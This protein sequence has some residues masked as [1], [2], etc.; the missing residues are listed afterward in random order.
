MIVGFFQILVALNMSELTSK[1]QSE[2]LAASSDQINSPERRPSFRKL[3]SHSNII[4]TL[5]CAC[6]SM[7]MMGSF[8]TTLGVRLERDFLFSEF[9]IN[10][11]YTIYPIA[12]LLTIFGSYH[13][14]PEGITSQFIMVVS[15]GL[16]VLASLMMGPSQF[17]SF[18]DT[19]I[20][21]GLGLILIGVSCISMV[22]SLP[23]LIKLVNIYFPESPNF[24]VYYCSG[25]YNSFLAAG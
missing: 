7:V 16:Q 2:E 8:E 14:I 17:L 23:E 18:P 10:V 13:F 20:I 3:M 12:Y 11:F 25:I 22:F 19:P 4:C 15:C 5:M 1:L 21:T 9:M 6:L 24:N